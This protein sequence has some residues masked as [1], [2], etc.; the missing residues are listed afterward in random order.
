MVNVLVKISGMDDFN[1]FS[2]CFGAFW[3]INLYMIFYVHFYMIGHPDNRDVT[4][5]QSFCV[6]T[7]NSRGVTSMIDPS[8]IEDFTWTFLQQ[9]L[10]G[11]FQSYSPPPPVNRIIEYPWFC[12]SN[13]RPI[14]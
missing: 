11:C 4:K 7:A 10:V 5:C 13:I 14:F 1:T 9:F 2:R 3:D 6:M 8:D 12:Y